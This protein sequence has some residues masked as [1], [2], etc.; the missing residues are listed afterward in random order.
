MLAMETT[1][2]NHQDLISY[3]LRHLQ[4]IFFTGAIHRLLISP[5]G[6]VR[7]RLDARKAPF[8]QDSE[9]V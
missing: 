9:A 6:T 2:K 3:K 7:A 8:L 4:H 5:D 1:I